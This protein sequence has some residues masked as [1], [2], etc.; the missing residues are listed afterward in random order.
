[1]EASE[2][3]VRGMYDNLCR[4]AECF[5]REVVELGETGPEGLA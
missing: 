5:E 2:G 3:L 1:M 4:V